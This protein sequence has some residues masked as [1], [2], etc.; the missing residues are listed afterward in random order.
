MAETRSKHGLPPLA[1][2]PARPRKFRGARKRFF[3]EMRRWPKGGRTQGWVPFQD[4]TR[5]WKGY[6]TEAQRDQAL[7]VLR[8]KNGRWY[9]FREEAVSHE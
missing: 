9:E 4:W 3:I 5:H 2:E 8:D 1:D 6:A 7:A